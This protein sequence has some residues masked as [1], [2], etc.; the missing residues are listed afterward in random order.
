MMIKKYT[1]TPIKLYLFLALFCFAVAA[2][3]ALRYAHQLPLDMYS[4]R[5]TQ[6]AL[7]SYWLVQ[8]GF[9]LA[10]ETPVAGPP[11]S[12]PFEFP[13]YQYLVALASQFLGI[14]LDVSGR[15]VSFIFLALCLV[16]AWSITKKLHFPSAVFYIFTA[17]LFSSPL[18]LYWGRTFMIETAA[19]FFSVAA[20]NYFLDILHENATLLSKLLYVLCMV[21]AILQ[22]ATTG[23]PILFLFCVIYV[24]QHLQNKKSIFSFIRSKQCIAGVIYFAVPLAIGIVW[25]LYTDHIKELNTLGAGLTS[26]ALSKWNWGTLHQRLSADLYVEVIWKR[27]FQQNLASVLGVLI[28][29]Y[30][31]FA[32]IKIRIKRVIFICCMM[33]LLPLFL[34][35]NLHI[36]HS[37]Y[38]AANV[39]F[40]IYA[41]AVLLGCMAEE[42]I[43]T[44]KVVDKSPSPL[45]IILITLLM[46]VSNY[47]YFFKKGSFDATKMEYTQA[48][49]HDYAV[50][51]VIKKELP[52]E[53]YVVIFG[54]DWSSSIAYLSQRKSF[55]VPAFF[56]YYKEIVLHPE[57][58][59][60][61]DT[62]GA[63]VL[64]PPLESPTHE[65]LVHWSGARNWQIREVYGCYIA[66]PA[67]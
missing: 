13:I 29:L 49:S 41:I 6:T 7:T 39:I 51:A 45:W 47:F 18:Y 33:G 59:F 31:V 52:Q 53:K 42:G 16:P 56:K 24:F 22:K 65:D 3:I 21:C 28:F 44:P 14:A 17:L 32:K 11:W 8:N 4:F 57:Q 30:P 34:F 50:A 35:P 25:T 26:H 67:K 58:F 46:V 63:V 60:E 62:L 19:V 36:I 40:F 38:Q 61:K 12:I 48:N 43:A 1:V 5:Q 54:N 20:I 66:L 15:V 64:C 10:Y 9:G 37:Y 27:I 23:L 55:T 2:Y